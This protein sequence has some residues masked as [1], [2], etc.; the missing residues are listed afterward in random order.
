M[1]EP[2]LAPGHGEGTTIHA[3]LSWESRAHLPRGKRLQTGGLL[4][5]GGAYI[6]L[7]GLTAEDTPK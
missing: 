6:R 7:V 3:S 1:Q 2:F 5:V 4:V